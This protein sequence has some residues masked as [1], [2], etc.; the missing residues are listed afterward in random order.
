DRNSENWSRITQANG[1]PD[2]KIDII[3]LDE[4]ILWVATPN[5][6]ASADIRIISLI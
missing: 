3:G 1:L 5:G 6:L 2:N 4:G